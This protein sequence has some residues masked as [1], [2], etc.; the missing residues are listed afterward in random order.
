MESLP[1]GPQAHFSQGS[2]DVGEVDAFLPI[3]TIGVAGAVSPG[4]SFF[5]EN[6]EDSENDENGE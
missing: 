1:H 4:A 2:S 3:R 6:C 5:D